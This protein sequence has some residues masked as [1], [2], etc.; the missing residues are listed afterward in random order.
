MEIECSLGLLHSYKS[1]W[2][3]QIASPWLQY[4]FLGLFLKVEKWDNGSALPWTENKHVYW[5]ARKTM[6]SPNSVFSCDANL[7]LMQHPCGFIMLP[8]GNS[9]KKS[10]CK[11]ADTYIPFCAVSNKDHC[12]WPRNLMSSASTHQIVNS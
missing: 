11:R 1:C 5:F 9:G 8:C 10:P 7:L 3:C 2:M 6:D 4:Y 12:L